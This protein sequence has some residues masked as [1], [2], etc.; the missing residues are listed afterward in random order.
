MSETI[1]LTKTILKKKFPESEAL[2]LAIPNIA[3][4]IKIKTTK[5]V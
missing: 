1:V 4:E 5:S 2:A 3:K